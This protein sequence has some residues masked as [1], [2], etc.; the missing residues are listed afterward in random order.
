LAGTGVQAVKVV[1]RGAE[2]V[3]ELIEAA[4]VVVDRPADLAGVLAVCA[5]RIRSGVTPPPA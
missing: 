4:D 5:E 3:A 2:P 1:V